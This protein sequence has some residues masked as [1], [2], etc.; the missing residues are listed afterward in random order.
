ML[1]DAIMQLQRR[2]ILENVTH[3]VLDEKALLL[4]NL[5]DEERMRLLRTSEL[6]EQE[7]AELHSASEDQDPAAVKRRAVLEQHLIESSEISTAL[8]TGLASAEGA[9]R[10]AQD[11]L[12]ALT[13]K[14]EQE[15]VKAA[16]TAPHIS[17]T[18]VLSKI[19]QGSQRLRLQEGRLT[20]R[21]LRAGIIDLSH[22]ESL[23]DAIRASGC[24]DVERLVRVLYTCQLKITWITAARSD[25]KFSMVVG[26]YA[27]DVLKKVML[28]EHLVAGG[29]ADNASDVARLEDAKKRFTE[30]LAKRAGVATADKQLEL[31]LLQVQAEH[32][33]MMLKIQQSPEP[34]S[35]LAGALVEARMRLNTLLLERAYS[36]MALCTAQM[37]AVRLHGLLAAKPLLQRANS[38]KGIN[39]KGKDKAAIAAALEDVKQFVAEEATARIAAHMED[40][41]A[42]I[43]NT[44]T[45]GVTSTAAAKEQTPAAREIAVMRR[46]FR[47][48][49]QG[50]AE[51][52]DGSDGVRDPRRSMLF[53]SGGSGIVATLFQFVQTLW[54]DQAVDPGGMLF[55]PHACMGN[56]LH[57][58]ADGQ[59]ARMLWCVLDTT[60]KVFEGY[61][62]VQEGS[63]VLRIETET[64]IS[65]LHVPAAGAAGASM[66]APKASTS[67]EMS[68]PSDFPEAER[69]F[70][71][72][73]S[74]ET[75]HLVA[76]NPAEMK[77]WIACVGAISMIEPK[78]LE[79][80][81]DDPLGVLQGDRL[82]TV[83]AKKLATGMI[84]LSEYN[85]I[86]SLQAPAMFFS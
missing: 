77:L 79:S 28:L 62:Q 37:L 13:A 74:E 56:L 75:C 57:Q 52:S 39:T 21:F 27:V 29:P 47:R 31:E 48:S 10:E 54:A 32:A 64:I 15:G 66:I 59:P 30:A 53:G 35:G 7:L 82:N 45:A 49:N 71:I 46:A 9:S 85:H 5:L 51:G 44:P 1:I 26:D 17:P 80:S 50:L 65:A 55:E 2:L 42:A 70:V 72:V 83:L 81:E 61:D 11:V 41:Q 68:A 78:V 34:G 86:K 38:R 12:K 14:D 23:P 20:D 69:Q 60:R 40:V 24:E 73:S 3:E 25:L 19:V 18:H 33:A 22:L 6:A 36:Q 67:S 8:D 4:A 58:P 16:E 76:P 84:T 63:P 43:F